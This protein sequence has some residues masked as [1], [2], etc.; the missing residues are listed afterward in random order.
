MNGRFLDGELL[1]ELCR[2]YERTINDGDVPN[3]DSA[4]NGLCKN[5]TLK[6]F[7]EAEDTID[8]KL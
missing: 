4:W 5:E 1:L 8:R 7:R 6:A 3:I 2:S